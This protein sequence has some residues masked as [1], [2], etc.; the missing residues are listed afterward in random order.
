[1][2][3]ATILGLLVASLSTA[4][5]VPDEPSSEPAGPGPAAGGSSTTHSP[6]K[7]TLALGDSYAFG[8]QPGKDANDAAAFNTGFAT[9]FVARLNREGQRARATEV[10]L[11]CPGETTETFRAGGCLWSEDFGFPLH[12]AYDGTQLAAA[13]HFLRRHPGQ[14]NPIILSLGTN[15]VGVPFVFECE[16]DEACIAAR[17]P[18]LVERAAV[19]SDWILHRLRTLAPDAQILVL[20]GY[21]ITTFPPVAKS[22]MGEVFRGVRAAARAHGAVLVESNPI[23]RSDPCRFT[24]ICAEPDFHPTDE[25]HRALADA[26]WA[27]SGLRRLS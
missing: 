2:T 8:L 27:A 14:V 12:E 9:L 7:F 4:C 10:N 6:G 21:R 16:E 5:S 13:L 1:M 17:L 15:D 11:S 22:A 25:G 18:R 3:R 23:I 26:L 24:F 20:V 19:N